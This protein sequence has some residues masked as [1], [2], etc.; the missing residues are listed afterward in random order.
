M[1]TKALSTL[2]LGLET[3]LENELANMARL[4]WAT[5]ESVGDQSEY[6]NLSFFLFW[7]NEIFSKV[8]LKCSVVL[9]IPVSLL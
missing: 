9:G 4:P 2:V 6:G 8:L 3:R 5:L 7:L 1:I